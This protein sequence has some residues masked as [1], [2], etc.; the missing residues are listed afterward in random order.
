M[1]T[2]VI[3]DSSSARAVASPSRTARNQQVSEDV[4]ASEVACYAYCAKAW[5]LEHVLRLATPDEVA[6]RR[7]LGVMDHE[8]H[9]R[10][11]RLMS[12]LVSRRSKVILALL[13]V[14]VLAAAIAALI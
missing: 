14:A 12:T 3:V 13:L 9:G 10:R 8:A 7:E 2:L 11:V 1:Q 6:K 4:T 5:H